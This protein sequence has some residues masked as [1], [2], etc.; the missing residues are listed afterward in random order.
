MV[1]DQFVLQFDP[2]KIVEL[3]TRYS[4]EQDDD[5]FE[6]GRNIA[7]G[8]YT[9]DNLKVIVR[10]KSARKIALLDDNTD[11]QL[12][13]SLHAASNAATPEKSAVEALGR[14]HGVGVPIASAILTMINPE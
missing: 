12:A 14:L 2:S 3:A 10:W 5:A 7:R 4:Y 1:T 6:A 11:A 13:S 9:R 8:N